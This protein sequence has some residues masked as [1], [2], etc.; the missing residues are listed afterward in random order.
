M[1]HQM[2][3]SIHAAAEIVT[4]DGRARLPLLREAPAHEMCFLFNQLFQLF[5]VKFVIAITEQDNP[6]SFAAV[7]I[8]H[9]PIRRE[10]LERDE[11][12]IATLRAG[13]G[14]RAEHREKE[15][16]NAGFV[17]RRIFKEQQ[18]QCP[19]MLQAKARS[20]L[21]DLVIELF[22]DGLNT[23]PGVLRHRRASP[24]CP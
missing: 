17:G 1:L 13:A 24:Q 9:V 23:Q 20:V 21:V 18:C 22:G 3:R 2:P 11:Q 7:F 8:I 10:L 12:I 4:A 19:G 5:P 15:R 16:V 6:V 14:E